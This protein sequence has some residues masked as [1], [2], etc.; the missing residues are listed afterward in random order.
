MAAQ[1]FSVVTSAFFFIV[2]LAQCAV[3]LVHG[4]SQEGFISIDCGIADGANY[5]DDDTKITNVPDT[6]YIDAGMNRY[7]PSNIGMKS[8]LDTVY[9]TVRSFPEGIR[10]CYKLWPVRPDEKYLVR[11]SFYYGNYDNK[12]STPVFDLYIG[13]NLWR[14]IDHLSSSDDPFFE[15]IITVTPRNSNSL[16]VCLVNMG[17]GTPFI[18]ALE[19]R[20][21][22]NS[23]YLLVNQ[24]QSLVFTYRRNYGATSELRYSL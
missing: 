10:N 8:G 1:G 22:P 18:S 11:A 9:Q 19:L 13:V 20:P 21:L 24:S 6:G 14:T 2:A 12:N 16:S 3:V 4:Q 17:R 15:E 5:T 7:L 23:M